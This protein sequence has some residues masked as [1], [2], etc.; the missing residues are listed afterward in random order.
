M[1]LY[2]IGAYG[3]AIGWYTG[4]LNDIY[5]NEMKLGKMKIL[6][7]DTLPKEIIMADRELRYNKQCKDVVWFLHQDNTTNKKD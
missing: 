6:R 1:E 5:E 3:F 7:I 4:S 2:F